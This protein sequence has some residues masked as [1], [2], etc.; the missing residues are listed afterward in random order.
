M[1]KVVFGGDKDDGTRSSVNMAW[2]NICIRNDWVYMKEEV[3]NRTII[4]AT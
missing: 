1:P 2:K 3:M 4:N